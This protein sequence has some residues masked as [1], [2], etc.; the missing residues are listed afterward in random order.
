VVRIT[1]ICSALALLF[2][3]GVEARRIEAS[4]LAVYA[5]ARAADAARNTPVALDRYRDALTLAPDVTGVA[6]RA[7]RSGVDGGD[8]ALALRAAQ[9]L[10]RMGTVPPD[11]HLLLYISEV[12]ALDW[13]AARRRLDRIIEERGFDILVP[14]LEKWLPSASNAK[15]ALSTPPVGA[16]AAE[17]EAL[18]AAATGSAESAFTGVQA[19]TN[20]GTDRVAALRLAVADSLARHGQRVRGIALLAGRDPLFVAARAALEKGRSLKVAVD[21]PT[22]GAAYLLAR[23][24]DDLR[25][26]RTSRTAV[27][28]SRLAVFADPANPALKL[29]AARALDAADRPALA[30][31][32]A[33]EVRRDKIFASDAASL[34]IDLLDR[35]GRADEALAEAARRPDTLAERARRADIEFRRGNAA[36]AANHYR[37]AI[38]LDTGAGAAWPLLLAAANALQ[39]SGDWAESRKML[40]K[41]LAIAPNEPALL[42][43]LGYGLADRGEN[44]EH[45]L[46]LLRSASL[47]APDNAAITDSLGW[48]EYRHG[49]LDKAIPLLERARALDTTEPEI[50]EH[51]G[52]AYWAAGRR[53][54]A[55]YAWHAAR[56]TLEGDAADRLSGKIDRGLQ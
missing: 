49:R 3:S 13:R 27:T 35:L 26:G 8:Y 2:A 53:I 9:S 19:F 17:N 45:A 16:Y 18:L 7:Y 15:A 32:V 43:Q 50:A 10:E 12:R 5:K 30:L 23:F 39:A 22:R 33:E 51:L 42:N 6:F 54:E 11:A 24:A 48:A 47:A 40:D 21:S 46:V 31:A 34:R 56:E 36:V 38:A 37:T 29:I 1:R 14:L 28:L 55:R 20:L 25:G 52:D 4:G 44:I 41:A